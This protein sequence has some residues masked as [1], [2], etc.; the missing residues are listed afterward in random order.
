MPSI[1]CPAG[2]K[3]LGVLLVLA[4]SALASAVAAPLA[5]G[6]HLTCQ[7]VDATIVGTPGDDSLYGT[8]DDDVIMGLEG[9]DYI[10][11]GGGAD[12]LCGDAG[13]DE[14][15]SYDQVSGNDFN[16]GGDGNDLCR[17]DVGDEVQCESTTGPAS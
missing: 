8:E 6:S 17:I 14:L 16:D 13:N 3:W 7:G 11:G 5:S 9:D 10:E 4:M 2:P 15:V 12:V 1:R